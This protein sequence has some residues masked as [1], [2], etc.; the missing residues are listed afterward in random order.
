MTKF[1]YL[2]LSVLALV[3]FLTLGMAKPARAFDLNWSVIGKLEQFVQDV[4]AQTAGTMYQQPQTYEQPTPGGE[5]QYGGPS[6]EQQ[7]QM[8][9]QQSERQLKDMKRGLQG[10]MNGL[11]QFETMIKNAE[12]KGTAVPQ[13]IKDKVAKV[14][15]ILDKVKNAQS[16]DE[17]QDVDMG[18]MGTMMQELDE[19]RREIFE[20]AQRLEGIKRGI[21]GMEQGLKMFEKQIAK[22]EKQKI[23]V[24]S[25][26]AENVAKLKNVIATVKAAKT[27][28]EAE[29][30]G[31]EDIGD[32]MQTLDESRQKL[33]ILARWPQTLKQLDR[34]ITRLNSALKRSKSMA[35]RLLKKEI[36]VMGHYTAF[37]EAVNKLKAVRNEAVTKMQTGESDDAFSLLEDSF[38]GQMEDIWQ[39]QK[40][41]EMMGNLGRFNADVKNG[42]NQS[43]QMINRL[44]RQKIDTTELSEI[45]AEAKAKAEEV[46]NIMKEKDFDE[47]AVMSGI[48]EMENLR[49]QFDEKVQELTG[50]S[51]EMPWEKGPQQFQSMQMS[52]GVQRYLPQKPV[53]EQMSQPA[54][55]QTCNINGVEV[56]GPC[57][58]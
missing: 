41:I 14:K 4:R 24:P 3:V 48:D 45:L 34:E 57:P 43:Q 38:F 21:K 5:G 6:Q 55:Q 53:E 28:D 30:A 12:K 23:S 31:I 1:A 26:V 50:Q 27:W 20:N 47:E 56:P 35:D 17:L 37:E 9:K 8:Q 40:V 11:R 22:L 33:E 25:D 7:D 51:D 10:Q 39:N 36:D 18:E 58:Q 46:K 42:L 29:S 2:K 54:Q 13:E 49:Q 16:A 44:K 15:E 32:L 52:P 19:A